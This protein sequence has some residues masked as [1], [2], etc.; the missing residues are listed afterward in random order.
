LLETQAG[1]A[2]EPPLPAGVTPGHHWRHNLFRH[3]RERGSRYL[4]GDMIERACEASAGFCFWLA[5]AF[6]EK[7]SEPQP[8]KGR[9]Y[10]ETDPNMEEVRRI[11]REMRAIHASSSEICLRLRGMP[12]PPRVTWQ[13][14]DWDKA[15]RNPR[16][17]NAV[18]KWISQCR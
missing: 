3:L 6:K 7:E 10:H 2:L 9:R 1:S 12:R 4:L 13:H 14:Y 15:Y 5:T 18:G 17:R 16:Y 11:I 8:A